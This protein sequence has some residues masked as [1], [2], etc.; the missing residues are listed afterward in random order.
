[1]DTSVTATSRPT[2]DETWMAMA[3]IIAKRS[4][5]SRAQIGCVIVAGDQT[6]V[7]ASY[8]GAP[9]NMV[10]DGSCSHWCPRAINGDADTD[11]TSCVSSHAEMNAIARSDWSRLKEATVYTTGTTC[12]NCAKLIAGAGV[13]RLVHAVRDTDTHRDPLGVESRLKAYGVE[14]IRAE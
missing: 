14:V 7:A 5:C 6:V 13:T 1:M 2:W 10:T 11:Y 9:P 8:N 3:E 4:K 12:Y